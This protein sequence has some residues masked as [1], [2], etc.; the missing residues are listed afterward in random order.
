MA[1]ELHTFDPDG[2]LLL[3]LS[4]PAL[5]AVENKT[6]SSA[7]STT[8]TPADS[9]T[10]GGSVNTGSQTAAQEESAAGD[11][12]GT[13]ADSFDH[14]NAEDD[15][16]SEEKRPHI[17]VRMLVSSKHMMLASPVFKAM[18]QHSAFKE[19]KKLSSAGKV[20]VPLP[21]DDPAPFKIVL[22]IIHGRNKQVPRK[23]DLDTLTKISIV[24]DK[25]QMTEG[26]QS[27]SEG[28][29]EALRE[30]LPTKYVTGKDAQL[31]H[32]WL[33]ISWVFERGMEFRTM[34]QLI[35]RGCH[36]NLAEDIEEGLPIPDLIISSLLSHLS[37]ISSELTDLRLNIGEASRGSF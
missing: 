23:I 19:G 11:T 31:V 28:W 8:N 10:Q 12:A 26:V 15:G 6:E 14:L 22:D 37:W 5:D 2:D 17:V 18:L 13:S 33:G 35:E 27:Y 29:I 32:R 30:D 24:V 1:T 36:S 3:I 20:E 16:E 9:E 4:R 25:Y 21:D 7:D 34:T